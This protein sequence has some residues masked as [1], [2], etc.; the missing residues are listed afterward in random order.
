MTRTVERSAMRKV[1][2][3]LLPFAI[4]TYFSAISTASMSASRGAPARLPPGLAVGVHQT[5]SPPQLDRVAERVQAAKLFGTRDRLTIVPC[6]VVFRCDD[7]I[8]GVQVV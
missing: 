5:G 2:L 4:L 7:V 1:Y 6:P 8:P 3:R